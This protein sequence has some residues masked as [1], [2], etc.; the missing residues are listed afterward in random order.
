MSTTTVEYNGWTNRETW[1]ANLWLTNDEGGYGF[2]E[3][4]LRRYDTN[5]ARAANLEYLLRDQME[6]EVEEPD[7]FTELLATAFNRVNWLEIIE[8]NL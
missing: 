3:G 4:I 6:S 1:L 8:S 2:F 7:M 5:E